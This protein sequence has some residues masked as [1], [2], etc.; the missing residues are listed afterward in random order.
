MQAILDSGDQKPEPMSPTANPYADPVPMLYAPLERYVPPVLRLILLHVWDR[1]QQEATTTAALLDDCRWLARLVT[2]DQRVM[3]PGTEAEIP[4]WA[5]LKQ[6]L[7]D[8]IDAAD[9]PVKAEA[10]AY[11]C[12]RLLMPTVGERFIAG[13][14][15]PERPF[16]CWWYTLHRDNTLVA[17]H[18]VNAD[19]PDSPLA[20][21]PRFA[22]DLLHA[23][24]DARNQHPT[25]TH[26][27]CGSWLNHHST[28]MRLWPQLYLD[29]RRIE[30][31]AGGFG[32]GAWGQYM[33]ADGAFNARRAHKL[34]EAGLH[35]YPLSEAHCQ[36][37]DAV[38]H[39][40]CLL[41]S[42]ACVTIDHRLPGKL[43]I[44]P[45]SRRPDRGIRPG[46][47]AG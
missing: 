34:R 13:Y 5:S 41:G 7:V 32:P 23:M 47:F 31:V 29:S 38:R 4:G 11:G 43:P 9:D 35:P 25:I 28:F 21:L 16:H 20:D 45:K 15:M 2:C 46:P 10:M 36:V 1:K 22:R 6:E 17:V 27:E 42:L 24:E 18:L 3:S 19:M 37:G 39:L 26:V 40:K 14:R 12:M 30:C 8:R 44:A 33:T